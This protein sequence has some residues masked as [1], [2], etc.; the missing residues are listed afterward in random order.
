M[1][2]LVDPHGRTIDYLRVSVTDRCNFRCVYCM[3]EQGFPALPKDHY[4]TADETLRIVRVCAELGITKVRLTGGEPLLRKDLPSMVAEMRS[5]GPVGDISATTNGFLLADMADDLAR[6]GLTRVNISLDSLDPGKFRQ[7]A[8]RGSLEAVVTGIRAAQEAGLRPLKINCVAMKG[9]NDGEFVEFARWTLDQEVH[10]RF[11]ELMPIRWNLDG[12]D[13]YDVFTA[14]PNRAL[15]QI[16]QAPGEMLS[17]ATMRRMFVPA[18]E[19]RAAIERELGPLHPAELQTNGPAQTYRLAG[20]RG[21]VGMISQISDD[22]CTR[23]NR[24]RLTH[25]GCLRPCLMSDGEV[26]LRT[27]LRDGAGD[28]RLRDLVWQAVHN[29]PARHYLAQ[30]QT[31]SARGMS[32][33]GG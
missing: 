19:I 31:V 15:L 8:R 11:I 21:T 24:L 12:A 1:Q 3:P 9:V 32:Q 16:R 26:D 7:I 17:D 23:C 4:L 10:V 20:A 29:K 27:A 28:D 14:H 33:I 2:R 22:L 30:G 25:D 13:E 5:W 18:A 6:A